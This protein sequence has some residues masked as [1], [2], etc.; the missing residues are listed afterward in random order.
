MSRCEL[1]RAREL[2]QRQHRGPESLLITA[3]AT[4]ALMLDE[5]SARRAISSKEVHITGT[6]DERESPQKGPLK[7]GL[8]AEAAAWDAA[9]VSA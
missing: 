3:G 7:A 6:R 5:L 2:A 8:K 1:F 4:R 9:S